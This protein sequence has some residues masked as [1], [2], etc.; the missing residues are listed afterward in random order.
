M[1]LTT[2]QLIELFKT[3]VWPA[4]VLGVFYYLRHEIKR[5]LPRITKFGWSGFELGTEQ[6]PSQPTSVVSATAGDL[7]T[8]PQSGLSEK[9]Q[10]IASLTTKV[11]RDQLDPVMEYTRNELKSRKITDPTDQSE[12]LLYYAAALAVV[13]NH[14]RNYRAIF[15]SQ[16]ELLMQMDIERGMEPSAARAFYDAA[17]AA[18]PNAYSYITFDVWFSF[19]RGANLI[20]VAPNGNYVLTALGRGFRQYVLDEH[21]PLYKPL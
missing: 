7:Q 3:G 9:Q 16:L 2:D 5:A 14:D 21:L 1:K 15:G 13:L 8:A 17:K 11:S 18:T 6:T 20:T 12:L 4:L 10:L 19:F